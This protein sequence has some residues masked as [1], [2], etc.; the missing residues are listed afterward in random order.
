MR[1]CFVG[2]V[3]TLY[4]VDIELSA[5]ILTYFPQSKISVNHTHSSFLFDSLQLS[6]KLENAIN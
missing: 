3:I 4:S 2:R 1:V 6:S 5:L